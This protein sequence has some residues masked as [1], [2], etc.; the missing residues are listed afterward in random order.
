MKFKGLIAAAFTPFNDDY[1]VALDKIPTMVEYYKKRNLA[2]I[3]VCGSTGECST[4]TNEERLSVAETF[5]GEAAGELPVIVHVGSNS[6]RE[7]AQLAAHA[8]QAGAVAVAAVSPS[9]F[10]PGNINELVASL[11]VIADAAPE[12]PF[13]FYHIPCLTGVNFRMI[14]FVEP[15]LENIPN[16]AGIKYTY[17]DMMDFQLCHDS[18]MGRYQMMF[19]RDEAFLAGLA[20]GAEAAVGSTFNYIP[21]IYHKLIED[22]ERGDIESARAWQRKSQL[23]VTLLQKYDGSTSKKLMKLAGVDVGPV[24]LPQS[25]MSDE[26]EQEL[27]ADLHRLELWDYL[28]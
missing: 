8:Q 26:T 4:L 7:G 24:R 3:F 20:M 11:K 2:A 18:E 21:E 5:I 17:E 27:I 14:D 12:L 15:A 9:Y 28:G 22:F 16:F 23:L 10:K 25:N 19:G 13:Y 1:S 6:V